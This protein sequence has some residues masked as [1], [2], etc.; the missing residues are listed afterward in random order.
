ML[1]TTSHRS[2]AA[3][4]FALAL[5]AP[6]AHA[7]APPSR[8]FYLTSDPVAPL[9]ETARNHPSDGPSS[10]VVESIDGP[11]YAR[12]SPPLVA[13]MRIALADSFHLHLEDREPVMP[14]TYHTAIRVLVEAP[15]GRVLRASDG[16]EYRLGH[17]VV[18]FD[19]PG[20]SNFEV[21][22]WTDFH[23]DADASGA[24]APLAIEGSSIVVPAG[25]RLMLK[26]GLV[27]GPDEDPGTDVGDALAAPFF[28][29]ADAL[30]D[31][32]LLA[33]GVCPRPVRDLHA[34][35]VCPFLDGTV[36]NDVVSGFAESIGSG[37]RD[38]EQLDTNAAFGLPASS[39][40]ANDLA[41]WL[42]VN[43]PALVPPAL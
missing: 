15:D 38:N 14:G 9:D 40:V 37:L 10:L 8:V 30:R 36:N 25:Y 22:G 24:P 41:S 5:V 42:S 39:F 20:S 4:L 21:E 12:N 28:L 11:R 33:D 18:A 19:H 31:S 3:C 7:H 32:G 16:S 43:A 34:P 1:G 13:P 2:I 27:S 6:V 26:F 17:A 23:F 29:A 35:F